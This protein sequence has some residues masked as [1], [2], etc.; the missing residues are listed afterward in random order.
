MSKLKRIS[1]HNKLDHFCQTDLLS[2]CISGATTM[3][4]GDSF[5]NR[6]TLPLTKMGNVRLPVTKPDTDSPGPSII[7]SVGFVYS[8]L[9]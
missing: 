8:L 2:T 9:C 5:Q 1:S 4:V 7:P 3:A 6:S